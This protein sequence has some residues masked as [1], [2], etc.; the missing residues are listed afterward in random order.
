MKKMGAFSKVIWQS[1]CMCS[2]TYFSVSKGLRSP[3]VILREGM[4][5]LSLRSRT[6]IF[7]RRSC[8]GCV[9]CGGG[10]T[11]PAFDAEVV[12][13]A[14]GVTATSFPVEASPGATTVSLTITASFC[15]VVGTAEVGTAFVAEGAVVGGFSDS[16]LARTINSPWSIPVFALPSL[17]KYLRGSTIETN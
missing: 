6:C 3:T 10:A 11:P 14:A 9:P 13:G 15:F 12:V 17:P 2:N 8:R 5:P 4:P 7:S 1:Q 16:N